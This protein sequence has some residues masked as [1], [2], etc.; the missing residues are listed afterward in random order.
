[1]FTP[2]SKTCGNGLKSRS[3]KCD[4]PSPKNN[5]KNCVG[6]PVENALCRIKDCPGMYF[7]FNVFLVYLYPPKITK[8]GYIFL[9]KI[10]E[11]KINGGYSLIKIYLIS[12]SLYKNDKESKCA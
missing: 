6:S 1:M 12:L 5:G 2:C 9:C 10:S 8:T 11:N 7:Y 4:N 3:R